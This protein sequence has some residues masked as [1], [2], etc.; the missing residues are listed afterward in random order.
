MCV[1]IYTQYYVLCVQ[2]SFMFDVS[3]KRS[4]VF[5][6]RGSFALLLAKVDPSIDLV[7]GVTRCSEFE[8][9]DLAKYVADHQAGGQ[10]E[11]G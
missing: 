5:C 7:I 3:L 1:Y 4:Q 10:T 2:R 6:H 9:P 8:G 11:T